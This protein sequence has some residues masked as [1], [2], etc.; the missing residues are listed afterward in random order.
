VEVEHGGEVLESHFITCRGGSSDPPFGRRVQ[1][2]SRYRRG[3]VIPQRSFKRF[4][5]PLNRGRGSE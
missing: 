4:P 2:I 5:L 1:K 3:S